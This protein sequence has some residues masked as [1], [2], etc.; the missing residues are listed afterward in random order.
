MGMRGCLSTC[1]YRALTHKATDTMTIGM[2]SGKQLCLH[3]D[4]LFWASPKIRIS[5]QLAIW[6][7]SLIGCMTYITMQ[8]KIWRSL[9][10]GWRPNKTT[11]LTLQDSK[12]ATKT[13]CTTLPRQTESHL[14][15]SHNGKGPYKVITQMNN[16]IYMIQRHPTAKI[17]VVHLKRLTPYLEANWNKQPYKGNNFNKHQLQK[18]WDVAPCLQV[19]CSSMS[20]F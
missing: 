2:V 20:Y 6:L 16:V 10:T 13:G 17:M 1:S 14:S 5:L 4:L 18:L 11:G 9:M 12:K 7:T 8:V 3:C 19:S 15:S